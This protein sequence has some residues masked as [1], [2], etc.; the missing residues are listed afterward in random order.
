MSEFHLSANVVSNFF[1]RIDKYFS[2]TKR[3]FLKFLCCSQCDSY[4]H[5]TLSFF[6]I[7]SIFLIVLS[8]KANL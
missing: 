8:L 5:H 6:C 3:I 2:N 7:I 1:A 4:R